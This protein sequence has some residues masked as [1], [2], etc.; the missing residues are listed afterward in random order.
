MNEEERF[1]IWRAEYALALAGL[2]HLQVRVGEIVKRADMLAE[3]S[4]DMLI[5]KRAEALARMAR[6]M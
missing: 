3:A 2:M 6:R 1:E 5:T 4:T